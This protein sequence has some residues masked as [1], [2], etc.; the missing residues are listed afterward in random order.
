MLARVPWARTTPVVGPDGGSHFGDNRGM[1]PTVAF[2]ESVDAARQPSGADGAIGAIDRWSR[3]IWGTRWT[4][5]IALLAL[6]YLIISL[7]DESSVP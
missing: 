2:S 5:W 6:A 1:V 7:S 4:R 3:I